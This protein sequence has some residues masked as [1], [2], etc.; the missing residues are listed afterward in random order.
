MHFDYL[1][2]KIHVQ[3]LIMQT[4]TDL[5][6]I[7]I[8]MDVASIPSS[9]VAFIHKSDFINFCIKGKKVWICLSN[10][11]KEF[12]SKTLF[13]SKYKVVYLFDE[14]HSQDEESILYKNQEIKLSDNSMFI[15][16][17]LWKLGYYDQLRQ[18]LFESSYKYYY[19]DNPCV[20]EAAF[21]QAI[22]DFYA[23]F[24]KYPTNIIANE[25]TFFSIGFNGYASSFFNQKVFGDEFNKISEDK[26]F[27]EISF[28]QHTPLRDNY[29][30][31]SSVDS[32][33]NNNEFI[34]AGNDIL[35]ELPTV[36]QIG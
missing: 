32:A 23:I 27:G 29:F 7:A 24:H 22:I 13:L 9:H 34:V 1:L 16:D 2:S 5:V 26:L 28:I 33:I 36:Y 3:E 6:P 20:W 8:Y 25:R 35:Y 19:L 14:I 11:G 18:I 15:L 21:N 30:V 12:L 10:T 31:L 17:L 4:Y